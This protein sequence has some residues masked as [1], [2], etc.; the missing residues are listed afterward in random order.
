MMIVILIAGLFISMALLSLYNIFFSASF[1]SSGGTY[2]IGHR[3]AAGLAPENTLAAIDSGISHGAAY[4][5]IDVRQTKDGELII[6]HDKTVDRTTTGTG[7]VEDLTSA[8]MNTL[9]IKESHQKISVPTLKEVLDHCRNKNCRILLEIKDGDCYPGIIEN[10]AKQV[11]DCRMEKQ[12]LICSFDYSY[13]QKAKVLLPEVQTGAFCI[14]LG[15]LNEYEDADF[16][17]PNQWTL[18]FFPWRIKSIHAMGA[19]TFVW[20]VN[21]PLIMKYLLAKAVDGIITD[22]P[23][24]LQKKVNSNNLN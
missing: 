1:A 10:I 20:T 7:S 9:F 17:C 19:K 23:D 6:M 2:I 5:E 24:I 18:V 4:V 15:R 16:I 3:G 22:R 14:G 8:Y 12:I 13:V 11:K 21:Q